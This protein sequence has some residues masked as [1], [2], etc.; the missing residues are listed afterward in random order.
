MLQSYVK[1]FH[2]KRINTSDKT[3]IFI[4]YVTTGYATLKELILQ[5]KRQ[6]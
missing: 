5:T 6:Y 4:I 2:F 3:P 1:L